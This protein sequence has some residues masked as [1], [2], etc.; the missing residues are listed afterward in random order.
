[1][2]AVVMTGFFLLASFLSTST[3]SA[4]DNR[5]RL[6]MSRAEMEHITPCME[7]LGILVSPAQFREGCTIQYHGIEFWAAFD[8]KQQIVYLSTGSSQYRSSKGL[9]VG[10]TFSEIKKQHSKFKAIPILGY[11]R[12]IVIEEEGLTF[13]FPWVEDSEGPKAIQDTDQ[14]VWLELE[15][16]REIIMDQGM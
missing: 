8:D 4:E 10:S 14:V 7:N 16:I 12:L 3:I 2:P 9:G 5:I 6:G 15:Q 11:G 13:G 1:M